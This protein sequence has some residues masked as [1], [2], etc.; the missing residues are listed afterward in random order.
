MREVILAPPG[1]GVSWLEQSLGRYFLLP[2]LS[3]LGVRPL[4][5][6][7]TDIS[8]QAELFV[9][10]IEKQKLS[11][12]CL[13][14]R[15][16]WLEDSSRNWSVAMVFEHMLI[17]NRAIAETIDLLAKGSKPAILT[18]TA[19]VK[20]TGN[21]TFDESFSAYQ[22]SVESLLQIV[23]KCEK[24]GWSESSRWPHPWFGPLSAKGWLALAAIHT[25]LHLGQVKKILKSL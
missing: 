23:D 14:A 12:R 5:K 18:G 16:L 7:F 3:L 20:P 17:V 19:D 24:N 6:L 22:K 4:K 9:K 13:I 15:P 2:M 8:G 11:V 1:A 21:L 25:N 10:D